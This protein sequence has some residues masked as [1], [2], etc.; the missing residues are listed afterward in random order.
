MKIY[1]TFDAAIK[2]ARQR[3]IDV[4]YWI[5]PDQWQSIDVSRKPEMAMREVLNFSFQVILQGESLSALRRDIK[6]NLPWADDHF[7]ER[8]GGQPLNPG[9]EWARWPWGNS[10]DKFRTEKGGQFSHTYM[11]RMWPR[12]A[13]THYTP[14]GVIPDDFNRNDPNTGIRYDYGDLR[15]VIYHLQKHP[16]S[17]QAYLPIWFPEDTGVVHGER[18][19]CTLGYHFIMRQGHLHTVYYIRSCDI[20]RHFQDDIY[21]SVRLTLY[22]L[23]QLRTL[24][25][26][27]KG[28]SP[29]FFTMH[30]TSLHAFKNDI[31]KYVKDGKWIEDV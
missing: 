17:R 20:V 26:H 4:G 1:P 24:D 5:H 30:I 13:G 8:V 14:D 18:V 6:P 21:L 29:G 11:E 3:L 12:F 7:M 28:I 9:E 27:W 23:N 16:L 15:D 31:Q 10:A 22:I 2:A 19:P 25:K